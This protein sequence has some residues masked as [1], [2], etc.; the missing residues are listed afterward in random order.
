[1]PQAIGTL[2]ACSLAM[3]GLRTRPRTDVDPP[4]VELPSAGGIS[5]RR[6]RGDNLV[7]LDVLMA[8]RRT[9]SAV[10]PLGQFREKNKTIV[11]IR[12]E[13]PTPWVSLSIRCITKSVLLL[14][15]S[16]RVYYVF[17]ASPV[18]GHYVQTMF[19]ERGVVHKTGST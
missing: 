9:N 8:D 14:V 4:R 13:T 18:P 2:A 15:V 17:F 6:P 1:M 19:A 12:L 16:F 11:N 5:S 3:C 10:R 7:Y